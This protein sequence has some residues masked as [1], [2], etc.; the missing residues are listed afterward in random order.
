M[1]WFIFMRKKPKTRKGVQ[2]VELEIVSICSMVMVHKEKQYTWKK[3]YSLREPKLI[4]PDLSNL[5][6]K[7]LAQRYWHPFRK[8]RRPIVDCSRSEKVWSMII[9]TM[10]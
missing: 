4:I 6:S 1:G 2:L 3:N 10:I 9:L 8:N 7:I 5:C